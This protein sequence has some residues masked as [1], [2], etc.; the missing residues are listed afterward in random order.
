MGIV[1]GR[2]IEII[3]L[4]CFS[5]RDLLNILHLIE[6]D[7]LSVNKLVEQEVILEEGARSL[8]AMD[9]TSPIGMAIITRFDDSS[10]L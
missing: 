10:R 1:A 9:R 4:H 2:K 3:G 6:S 5:A 7:I 8:M